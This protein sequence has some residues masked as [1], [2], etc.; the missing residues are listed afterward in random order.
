MSGIE[1]KLESRCREYVKKKM[2][3]DWILL[4][5][6]SPGFNG[7]SDRLLLAYG[8]II[9]IEFK[10]PGKP[11]SRLQEQFSQRLSRLKLQHHTCDN[12]EKFVE[13]CKQVRD[14]A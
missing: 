5:W 3:P 10:A 6:R 9:P 12:F 1:A 7:V 11:L 13:I 2:P 14:E 4:K 8:R